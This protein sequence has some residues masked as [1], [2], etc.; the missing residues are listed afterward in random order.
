VHRGRTTGRTYETPV[1]AAPTEDGFVIRIVYGS[2][3]EWLRNVLASGE[4]A[5]VCQGRTYPV[6]RPEIVPAASARNY[7]P[8]AIR[9][10]DRLIRVD[11][12]LR[13]RRVDI[14]TE[15]RTMMPTRDQVIPYPK[16]RKFMEAAIRST[17]N[18]PMMHGLVEID[19][20]K[21]RAAL[22]ELEAATGVSPSF[23]AF[24]IGCLG[25]AV[26][27]N[28]YVHVLR[29]GRKHLMLFDDVDVLTWIERD[30]GG[31][32]A[33]M[34][35]IVRAANRKT[36]EAINDEIRAAQVEDL[37][38][39][40]VAGAKESQLLPAVLYPAFFELATR[41]GT[42]FPREWKRRWGTITLTAVGMVDPGVAFWGVPPSSPSACWITVGG[43]AEKQEDVDGRPTRREYLSLTVSFD[44]RMLDASPAGRF[45]RRFKELLESGYGLTNLELVPAT[46]SMPGAREPLPVGEAPVVPSIERQPTPEPVAVA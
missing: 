32:P 34:P 1:W 45:V 19:V 21:A 9:L 31:Q 16:S 28:K 37:A 44:H 5:I 29:K 27:E 24:V 11:H 14:G 46:Q 8:A 23:T 6:G 42:W 17:H 18:K 26:H 3:T 2:R 41:L 43:I 33:V 36:F 38:K 15:E 13:V 12:C 22:R 10:I 40:D 35:C 4:A 20:T 7:F 25:R 39:F 30:A